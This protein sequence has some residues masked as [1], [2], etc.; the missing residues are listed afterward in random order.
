VENV[1]LN[2]SRK[3]LSTFSTAQCYIK[4]DGPSD[5]V[6]FAKKKVLQ[7]NN[8]FHISVENAKKLFE[9]SVAIFLID[10]FG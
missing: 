7:T 5:C 3:T 6:R 1:I 8:T 2:I 9:T 4:C 10:F